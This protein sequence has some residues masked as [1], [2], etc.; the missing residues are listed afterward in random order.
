MSKRKP[1]E[2]KTA[3]IAESVISGSEAS[4]EYHPQEETVVI[5]K[6]EN[7]SQ[8]TAVESQSIAEQVIEDEVSKI[9]QRKTIEVDKE[10]FYRLMATSVK[11]TPF[12][13]NTAVAKFAQCV[14]IESS[15][16]QVKFWQDDVQVFLEKVNG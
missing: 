5:P 13:G 4:V 15:D 2:E 12:R 8:E 11:G 10:L 1:K 3:S 14:G 7:V 9:K 16:A 6:N